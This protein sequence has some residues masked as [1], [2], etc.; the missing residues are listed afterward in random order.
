MSAQRAPSAT[1][2]GRWVVVARAVWLALAALVLG[3]DV[4]GI[5]YAYAQVKSTCTSASCAETVGRLTSEDV[6]VL[7]EAGLSADFYA[8]YFVALLVLIELAFASVAAVIFW[9][10]SEDRMAL[11][12]AFMLLVFGGAAFTSDVQQTLAAAHPVLWLPVHFLDYMGQ[13]AFAIFFYIFPSGRFVP[14][15]TRWLAIVWAV[16]WM[17]AV[18]FPHTPL[19]LLGGPFFVGYIGTLVFGQVYR[20]WRVSSSVERQQTKWVV[21]GVAVALVGFGVTITLA[22]L[23]P[24]IRESGPLGKLIGGALLYGFFLLIPVSIGVAMVRSRL[25][26]IDI[27]INRTLVYG[28]LTVLLAATYFAGVVGLQAALRAV[29]GQESTLAVVASTLAI[30]ALFSPLRRWVQALVDRRFYRSKYDARKTLEAF[31]VKLREETDLEALNN[32]LVGVI[33]ETMQPAHVSMW[34]R[35][36][37]APKSERAA[38]REPGHE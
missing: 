21:F 3:L 15:W 26:E 19:N 32:E 20:Y 5:P 8:A 13:V 9:R 6:Q 28:P 22:N 35:P 36:D 34:L 12:S 16:L 27:L 31:S 2:R 18:F 10:R 38:L 11:F 29:T 30:A 33:R 4:A 17:P 14:R 7:K 25:Y 24:A 37:P 23:I 1:M